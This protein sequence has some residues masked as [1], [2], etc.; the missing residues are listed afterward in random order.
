MVMKTAISVQRRN[1]QYPIRNTIF[2]DGIH[3]I[4]K[5]DASNQLINEIVYGPEI[6]EVL[7][8]LDSS[9]T[10]HYYHQDALESVVAVTDGFGNKSA[11]YEYDV[12]GK[13]KD[14]TGSFKNEITYT[15]R[16]LDED[17][18][19]YYYRARWYDASAGRFISRDPIG[20]VGGINLYGYVGGNSANATDPLGEFAI[21]GCVVVYYVIAAIVAVVFGGK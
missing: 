17:T 19:L 4:A 7:C 21:S 12:Y 10:A 6:D 18:G 20:T 9:A 3:C 8:S 2:Y 13:I 14:K 16:W 11:A 15:G 1:P 5:Y